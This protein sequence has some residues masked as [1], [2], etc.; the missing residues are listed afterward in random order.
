LQV[1]PVIGIA[2]EN[3]AP[4]SDQLPAWIVEHRYVGVLAELGAV[5][6]IVPL[7]AGDLDTLH[8][9]YAHFDGL[10][11]TGGV[12]VDPACYREQRHPMCG[13]TDSPRDWIETQLLQ[14][15]LRDR[16]PILGVCRG[17]Q[18]INVTA[19]GTLFQDIPAQVPGAL[20]HDVLQPG[21]AS[22]IHPA[23]IAPGSTLREIMGADDIEVNST[24]HQAIK[25]V[26]PGL[27][28]SAW[29]PD[30]VI[31]GI[32]GQGDKGQF[33]LGVQ[34]HPED[35]ADTNQ[36][37]RRLFQSFLTAAVAHREGR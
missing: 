9:M 25:D 37:M 1:R 29:A 36:A 6:W 4:S 19:G 13:R 12:D 24:H 8:A 33:L 27:T 22:I 20:Q 16:K 2:A 23:R 14:W 30:G 11:I 3:S 7:L 32:E 35:M 26:A 17:L 15:A 5:P 31:E 28:A 21:I 10:F 34:W 18:M